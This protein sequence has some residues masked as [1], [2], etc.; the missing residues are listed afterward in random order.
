MK[1]IP[2]FPTFIDTSVEISYESFLTFVKTD[3]RLPYCA[4]EQWKWW[5]IG[6]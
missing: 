1:N 4:F 3:Y 2:L 5:Q 6:Y